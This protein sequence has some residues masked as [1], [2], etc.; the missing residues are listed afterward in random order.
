M[1]KIVET[2][3][4]AALNR[5]RPTRPASTL[6]CFNVPRKGALAIALGFLCS[7]AAVRAQSIAPEPSAVRSV[8]E[9]FVVSELPDDAPAYRTPAL[10]ANTNLVR[11]DPA[12]LA[13]AVERF[14]TALWKELGLRLNTPWSGKIF[15]VVR[16]AIATNESVTIASSPFLDHWNYRVEMPDLISRMRYAR[17]L[18]AVLLLELANRTASPRG[19]SAEIP[20]WLVDGMARQILATDGEKV[21]LSAVTSKYGEMPV[22]RLDQT[23]HGLDSLAAARRTLENLPTLTFDELSWPTDAEMNGADGGAYLASAQLFLT[24]LLALKNGREKMRGFLTELPAHLN[25]Q[26]A[27][28]IAFGSEFKHPL[29]VEKWWS[30]RVVNFAAHA[31]GP[32]WT[33]DVSR[34]RLAELLSVPVEFRSE[35]NALPSHAEISLQ[36]ALKSLNPA[37]CDSALRLKVHDL[38][39][40]E[41]RLGPPFGELADGY[42]TTLAAFLGEIK[43]PAAAPMLNKHG[44]VR[45]KATLSETLRA[46]DALDRRRRDVETKLF[47]TL[48]PATG[49]SGNR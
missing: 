45:R 40:V 26:T 23:E 44:V 48:P 11:L 17:A 16:P 49:T 43:R 47:A 35:S 2:L 12:L 42:R 19:R 20:S 33:S 8:S 22:R 9:Q 4:R 14:K 13:V 32:R 3:K 25:W 38:A 29:D 10:F 27:F 5:H 31:A 37:Q 30:L 28:F 6:H 15:L 18:S 7:L 24:Q 41:L 1:P 36:A 46:L 21:V 39:M 34:D